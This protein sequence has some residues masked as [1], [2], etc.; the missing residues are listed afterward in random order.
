[1]RGTN[2]L[3]FDTGGYDDKDSTEFSSPYY[4]PYGGGYDESHYQS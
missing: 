2:N 3:R 4:N 1:M